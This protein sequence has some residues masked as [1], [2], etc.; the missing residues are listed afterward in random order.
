MKQTWSGLKTVLLAS[1]V[2]GSFCYVKSKNKDI[3]NK[4]QLAN[5]NYLLYQLMNEWVSVK[6]EGKNLEDY[7][8]AK[9]YKRIAIYGMNDVGRT[10][11]K[12]LK[13]TS[14]S[15]DY[16]IDQQAERIIVQDVTILKPD[17]R[18]P[19]VDAI[20]VAPIT[21]FEE[22]EAKLEL[23]VK[24]PVVSMEDIVYDM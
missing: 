19:E 11:I 5:K 21:F 3:Q 1:I 14:I 23:K 13:D 15:V 22:I 10:L 20:I 4:E 12:E 6:Q 16:V 2:V 9:N 17:D 24:C 18:L 7:F 8:L